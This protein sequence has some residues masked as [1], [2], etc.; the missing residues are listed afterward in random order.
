METSKETD[1]INPMTKCEKTFSSF[2]FL[3]SAL[4]WKILAVDSNKYFNL[5]ITE[6]E[7]AFSTKQSFQ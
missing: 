5:E 4:H 2:P 6:T 3:K 1:S 7:Q